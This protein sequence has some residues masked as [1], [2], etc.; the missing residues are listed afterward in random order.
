MADGIADGR[1]CRSHRAFADAERRIAVGLDE[2]DLHFGDL[3]ETQDR[4]ALPVARFPAFNQRTTPELNAE[5]VRIGADVTREVRKYESCYSVRILVP[6]GE[7]GR[8]EGLR[9]VANMPVE[10]FMQTAPRSVLS[11]L[12]KPTQDQIAKTFKGR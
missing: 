8:L 3:A 12:V 6:D 5:I 4:I 2:L 9:L 7:L 11:Y 10:A 1:R